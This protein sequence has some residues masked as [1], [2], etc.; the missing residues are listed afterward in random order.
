MESE[1]KPGLIRA[2]TGRRQF[3]LIAGGAVGASTLACVGLTAVGTYGHQPEISFV[4]STY[5]EANAVKDR[6]L[7]AYASQDG[8]T[9]G[10]ADA[11]GKQLAAGGLTVDVRQVKDVNDLGRYRSVVVG[12]AIHGGK[13]MPEAVEFVQTNQ[14][15]LSQVPTAYF[16]VSMM[17]ARNT[18]QDRRYVA[19]WLEPV[20]ALVK[21]VAE[22][23]FAGALWPSKH[24]LFFEGL[25]LRIFL[26]SIGLK[27]GDYRDWDAI[28]AWADSARPLL[29]R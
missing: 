14:S 5:G 13:W 8:S 23:W 6:I 27:E 21:P 11:L 1:G 24:P 4:E 29:L 3:L 28:R 17:M 12:S 16:L 10:V 9:G 26:S 18:E 7:V 15:R 22:G 20:R 19:Q 2:G 25:G